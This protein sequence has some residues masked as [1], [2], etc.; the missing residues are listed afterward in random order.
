MKER[1]M[2]TTDVDQENEAGAD[3]G[4]QDRARGANGRPGVRGRAADAYESARQRTT[5]LYGSARDR[6]NSAV[7][8]TRATAARVSQRTAESI[9][10][11][12]IAAVAGGLVLGVVLAAVLPRSRRET[13]LLRPLGSRLNETAREAADAARQAGK[14]KL[15]ELGFTR[16]GARE[17]LS[18]LA[19]TAGTALKISAGAAAGKV[20]RKR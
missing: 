14:D 19:S 2:A 13:D 4:G 18:A 16:E 17:K 12:P 11:A 10:S 8:S 5:D 7:E 1:M 9:E 20:R 15:D 6:A 3:T